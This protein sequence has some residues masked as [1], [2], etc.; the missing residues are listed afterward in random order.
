MAV[1]RFQ[2]PVQTLT[3]LNDQIVEQTGSWDNWYSRYSAVLA[4]PC[5]P[6][7]TDIVLFYYNTARVALDDRFSIHSGEIKGF[8]QAYRSQIPNFNT[9]LRCMRSISMVASLSP[10]VTAES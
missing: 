9:K 10:V 1:C 6:R 5:L 2:D 8:T 3:N 7:L 4:R